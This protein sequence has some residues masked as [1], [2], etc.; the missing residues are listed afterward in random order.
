MQCLAQGRGWVSMH[1][2][3]FSFYLRELM[4]P[5]GQMSRPAFLAREG[6]LAL[7]PPLGLA[8]RWQRNIPAHWRG[9]LLGEVWAT[10]HP[11]C[12]SLLVGKWG[13]FVICLLGMK[14]SLPSTPSPLP[15]A[16]GSV[17][18]FLEPGLGPLSWK[19]TDSELPGPWRSF[20]A[21]LT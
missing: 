1:S 19:L 11:T 15:A 7:V 10:P 18:R 4:Y 17:P 3:P 13:S 16:G 2:H 12:L 9:K 5:A 8:R 20:G 14:L 21:A 6:G